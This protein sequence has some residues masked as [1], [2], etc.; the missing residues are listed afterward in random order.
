[1]SGSL[2]G[3]IA[4]VTGAGRGIGRA[5]AL[6]YGRHGA[7]VCCVARTRGEI[8]GTA[9]EIIRTGGRA[10]ALPADVRDRRAVEAAFQGAARAF[11]GLDI[12]VINAGLTRSPASVEDSDPEAWR[13]AIDTNL[14]GAYYCARA[15]I[16]HLRRRGAGKIIAVGSGLGHRG[17]ATRSAYACSKAGL[18]MLTIVLAQELAPYNIS[19]NELVPG[20]VDTSMNPGGAGTSTSARASGS[21][22]RRTSFPWRSSW[23]NSPTSA[24]PP[25]ASA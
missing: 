15:A 13:E 9:A 16:P 21:R 18:W 24:P 3:K 2:E 5:I 4:L 8:E 19:V 17:V 14:V 10:L 1:M 23:R 12:V 6:A 22:R 11:D 25:R 20:P 7:A